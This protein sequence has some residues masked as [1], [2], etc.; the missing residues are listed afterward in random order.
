VANRDRTVTKSFR[1]KEFA[2]NAIEQEAK[3][4][5]IS[6]NAFVNRMFIQFDK[7][8]RFEQV[9]KSIRVPAETLKQILDLISDEQLIEIGKKSVL[10][11]AS[12]VLPITGGSSLEDAIELQ[13]TWGEA[14]STRVIDA[15]EKGKRVVTC[16]TGLGR[17]WAIFYASAWSTVFETFGA[18]PKVAIS[19]DIVVFAF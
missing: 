4:Q 2:I 10:I 1:L 5:G 12:H 6:T 11:R 16:F 13:K 14:N 15:N 17:K 8:D 3:R 19:G 9:N 7:V 18:S